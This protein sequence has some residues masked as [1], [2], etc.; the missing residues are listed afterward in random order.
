M[1]GKPEIMLLSLDFRPSFI[2]LTD[3]LSISQSY[4]AAV[5]ILDQEIKRR[6]SYNIRPGS[7]CANISITSFASLPTG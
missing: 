2:E 7:G 5:D 4:C 3:L 6:L 1:I